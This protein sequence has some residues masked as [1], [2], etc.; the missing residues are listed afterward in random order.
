MF[1]HVLGKYFASL[2]PVDPV[3]GSPIQSQY[4]TKITPHFEAPNPKH[5]SAGTAQ[6]VQIGFLKAGQR[7]VMDIEECPIATPIVNEG[8]KKMRSEVQQ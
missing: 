2:P 7:R 5:Q 1:F 6:P 3:S 4:R 8:M